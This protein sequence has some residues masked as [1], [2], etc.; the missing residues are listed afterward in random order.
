LSYRTHFT[1][2]LCFSSQSEGNSYQRRTQLR[3]KSSPYSLQTR[4]IRRTS[5]FSG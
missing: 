1:S 2:S 4:A 5:L 3:R